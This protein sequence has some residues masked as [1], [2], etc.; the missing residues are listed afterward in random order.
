MYRTVIHCLIKFILMKLYYSKTSPYARK[1]R[2]VIIEKGLEQKV[3]MICVNP[4]N[5]NPDL[6]SANPLG[7]IP[8]LLLDNGEALFDSPVICHYLDNLS[9]QPQLIPD[10]GRE[11]WQ[12]FCNEALADG[13]AD[14]TYNLVMERRRP[15]GEQSTSWMTHWSNEIHQSLQGMDKGLFEPAEK[16]TLAHLAIG[17]AIGYLELRI[18][19][20]LNEAENPE[21]AINPQL[22]RWYE[23][24]KPRHSMRVTDPG[25]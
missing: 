1:V 18:P 5:D 10:D 20:L 11:K 24:F 19:E 15:S 9:N 2:M 3:E 13:L 21:V 17:A 23:S 25:N 4:F 6:V 14:A 8:T 7:K 16:I 12:L 22:M